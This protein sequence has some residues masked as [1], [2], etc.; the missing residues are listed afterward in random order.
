VQTEQGL[1]QALQGWEKTDQAWLKA[2]RTAV[3]ADWAKLGTN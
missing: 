1:G 2:N 3:G